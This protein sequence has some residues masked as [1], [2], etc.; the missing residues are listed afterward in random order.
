VF[1]HQLAS[2]PSRASGCQALRD[3]P[4]LLNH[5]PAPP[6]WIGDWFKKADKNR[7][8]RMNFKETQDLL[9]MMNVEMNEHHAHRLFTVSVKR[10]WACHLTLPAPP[11]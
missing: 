3:C 6:R 7:D 10:R 4:V 11:S 5:R 9:R 1:S 2:A 8:G